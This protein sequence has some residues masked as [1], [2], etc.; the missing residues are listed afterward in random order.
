MQ[1]DAWTANEYRKEFG[2][3]GQWVAVKRLADGQSLSDADINWLRQ[4]TVH[5]V[6]GKMCD[7]LLAWKQSPPP[8]QPETARESGA[9]SAQLPVP[10]KQKA[11]ATAPTSDF[12]AM[13]AVS[14]VSDMED[15][16]AAIKNGNLSPSK[17]QEVAKFRQMQLN[18]IRLVVDA[19]R[20]Q[21]KTSKNG[22]E[23]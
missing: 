20:L 6:D 2:P 13:T 12:A 23:R 11:L 19:V 22:G 9:E 3:K 21:E 7:I 14:L 8:H 5:D 10:V 17:A 4:T 18:T 15:E 1:P 16:I